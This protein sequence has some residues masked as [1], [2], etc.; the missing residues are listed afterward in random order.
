MDHGY[1]PYQNSINTILQAWSTD[2]LRTKHLIKNYLA[3]RSRISWVH[4]SV[5]LCFM[6]PNTSQMVFMI[7]FYGANKTLYEI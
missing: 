2:Y 5:L 1:N 7:C 3:L 4:L 6:L